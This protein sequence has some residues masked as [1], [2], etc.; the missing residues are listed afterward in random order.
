MVLHDQTRPPGNNRLF[1]ASNLKRCFPRSGFSDSIRHLKSASLVDIFRFIRTGIFSLPN[2]THGA[3]SAPEQE[4]LIKTLLT[5][6]SLAI[7]MSGCAF[8]G[9]VT[10]TNRPSREFDI[11]YE[12]DLAGMEVGKPISIWIPIP[13]ND[14]HQKVVD[15][16]WSVGSELELNQIST[17]RENVYGNEMIYLQGVANTATAKITVNYNVVRFENSVDQQLFSKDTGDSPKSD[18]IYLQPSDLCFV[19]PQIEAY[20]NVLS[21]NKNSTMEIA[22]TFYEH[23]LK[24]MSYDKKGEGWGRG[25]VYHA[26]EVGKGNC[27]DF[28]T[29]FNALC[30]AA[31]IESRFQIGMWGKYTPQEAEFKTGGYHCWAEFHVPGKGWVPVDISEADKDVANK[32]NFFARQTANRVTLSTGRGL[33]LSPAQSGSPLNFFVN[34]YAEMDGKPFSGISKSCYWTDLSG[35][36]TNAPVTSMNR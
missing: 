19:T 24:E 8:T 14:P 11:R 32:A 23:I 12:V 28:H 2:H 16:K 5:F 36:S 21:A 20:A 9:G 35:V 13:H 6:L 22:Q 25:D 31:G 33:T 27:T 26:C 15:L 34:P 17:K 30:M 4:L 7:L 29:Y 1:F 3:S 18:S 10:D